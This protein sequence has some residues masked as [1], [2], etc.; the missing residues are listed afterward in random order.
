MNEFLNL[1]TAQRLEEEN[2]VQEI[3]GKQL[4]LLLEK[5]AHWAPGLLKGTV[6][7]CKRPD[8]TWDP[9]VTWI[10]TEERGTVSGHYFR[11]LPDAVADWERRS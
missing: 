11:N 2:L 5:T 7:L 6:V 3:D 8:V 1:L 4:V 10:K 9:Y